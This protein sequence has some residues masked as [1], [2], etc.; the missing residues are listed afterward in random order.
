MQF[1]NALFITLIS[2]ATAAVAPSPAQVCV[3]QQV[4]WECRPEF[5]GHRI[6]YGYVA[7]PHCL[8]DTSGTCGPC[9]DPNQKPSLNE[10]LALGLCDQK[11]PNVCVGG[12]CQVREFNSTEFSS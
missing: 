1:N 8:I 5:Q 10:I 11:F 4:H 12:L 7:M 9:F 3:N 2:A 6:T